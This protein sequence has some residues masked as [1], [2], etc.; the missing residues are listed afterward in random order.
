MARFEWAPDEVFGF[1]TGFMHAGAGAVLA[2]LWPVR[3]LPAALLVT[4]F[5]SLHRVGDPNS[6]DGPM[7]PRSALAQA[8]R[9]LRGLTAGKMAEY[10][11]D[12]PELG[13]AAGHWLD[14]AE[15]HPALKPFANPY[16]WAPYVI[17]GV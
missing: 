12:H 4:R 7:P 10:V 16:D 3:D 6:G 2:A 17:V 8:Q 14:R 11:R 13:A 9:W 5:Y 15:R 1:P